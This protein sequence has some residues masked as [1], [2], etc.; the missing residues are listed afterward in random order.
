M[1][2]PCATPVQPQVSGHAHATCSQARGQ[3]HTHS[4]SCIASI[5]MYNQEGGFLQALSRHM[6]AGGELHRHEDHT[7]PLG[8]RG[9]PHPVVWGLLHRFQDPCPSL[10]TRGGGHGMGQPFSHTAPLPWDPP[11]PTC[12]RGGGT[13]MGAF[14]VTWETNSALLD[15]V[16]PS[17]EGG[18]S[19]HMGTHHHLWIPCGPISCLACVREGEEGGGGAR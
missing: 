14:P 18:P 7:W 11:H 8:A 1:W 2:P 10:A 19:G 15:R 17:C 16:Q 12:A 5:H 4:H 3:W 6:G 9:G 13:Q